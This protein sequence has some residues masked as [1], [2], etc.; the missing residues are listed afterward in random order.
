MVMVMVIARKDSKALSGGRRCDGD[1]DGDG[2]DDGNGERE[3]VV[4]RTI[5]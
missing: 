2:D 5:W 4:E 1:G 3:G